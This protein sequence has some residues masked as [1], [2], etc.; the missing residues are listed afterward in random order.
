MFLM[1]SWYVLDV[2]LIC[3]DPHVPL[4]SIK[5]RSN[6]LCPPHFLVDGY[7]V[8][9]LQLAAIYGCWKTTFLWKWAIL[10]VYVMWENSE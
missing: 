7:Y 8:P 3:F 6:R 9:L 1:I 4:A 5:L 10:R 2:F